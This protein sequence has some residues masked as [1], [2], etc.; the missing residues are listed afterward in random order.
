MLR[1]NADPELGA[2]DPRIRVLHWL[3]LFPNFES[4]Y[5]T[6]LDKCFVLLE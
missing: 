1:A 5:N 3:T 2:F 6:V 4:H